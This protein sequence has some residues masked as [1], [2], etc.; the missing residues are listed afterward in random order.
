MSGWSDW[1][2]AG[3][4]AQQAAREYVREALA[5]E[6][7]LA[8]LKD[9]LVNRM[10][11]I[12][13][14]WVVGMIAATVIGVGDTWVWLGVGALVLAVWGAV[15]LPWRKGRVPQPSGKTHI[16][17]VLPGHTYKPGD[18]TT[19]GGV[20]YVVTEVNDTSITVVEP[21]K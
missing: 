6:A 18:R 8:D 15:V 16:V 20:R 21:D 5:E 12:Y 13:A 1:D 4:A 9:K 7:R 2:E 3:R 17:E 14:L 19:L 11:I 10:L